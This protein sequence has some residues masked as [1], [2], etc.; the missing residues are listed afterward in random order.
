MEQF[1]FYFEEETHVTEGR[2]LESP[3][4]LCALSETQDKLVLGL[5]EVF[6]KP[7]F[8]DLFRNIMFSGTLV[9]VKESNN[10]FNK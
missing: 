3:T 5:A 8:S 10:Q 1:A 9:C 2:N 7:V 4:S 6:L